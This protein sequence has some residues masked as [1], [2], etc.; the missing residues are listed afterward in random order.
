MIIMIIPSERKPG[1]DSFDRT[2]TAGVTNTHLHERPGI[3]WPQPQHTRSPRENRYYTS[4][5]SICGV[6]SG[7]ITRSDTNQPSAVRTYL[8]VLSAIALIAAPLFISASAY[9]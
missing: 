3:P 8:S 2:R 1:R 5:P 6:V 4:N 9:T 7:V